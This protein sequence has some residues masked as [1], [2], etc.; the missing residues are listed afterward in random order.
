MRYY[1]QI[2]DCRTYYKSAKIVY[3]NYGTLG[4]SLSCHYAM[5]LTYLQLL[6]TLDV[7]RQTDKCNCKVVGELFSQR[8]C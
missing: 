1:K 7:T 2:Y 5:L 6:K 4:Q 8:Q 3:I